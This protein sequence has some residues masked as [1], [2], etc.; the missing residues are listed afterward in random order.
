[1]LRDR[2]PAQSTEIFMLD[3][4]KIDIEMF[5]C[6]FIEATL[7]RKE[8]IQLDEKRVKR[9]VFLTVSEVGLNGNYQI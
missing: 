3:G 8:V 4:A 5:R 2:R 1:M 7:D 9:V 6:F